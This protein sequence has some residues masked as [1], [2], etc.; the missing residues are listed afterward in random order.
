MER[1]SPQLTRQLASISGAGHPENYN[2]QWLVHKLRPISDYSDSW[3]WTIVER[4][5]GKSIRKIVE[6]LY[7][8]ELRKGAWLV[9]I[10]IWKTLFDQAVVATIHELTDKGY[11]CLLPGGQSWKDAVP[12]EPKNKSGISELRNAVRPRTIESAKHLTNVSA[13]P[14]GFSNELNRVPESVISVNGARMGPVKHRTVGT[15]TAPIDDKPGGSERPE[16]RKGNEDAAPMGQ[17][18]REPNPEDTR[19]EP[20]RG[21]ARN[22]AGAIFF[23]GRYGLPPS[24]VLEIPRLLRRLAHEGMRT[25]INFWRHTTESERR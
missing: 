15:R 9:D 2:L 8:D 14:A 16:E 12:A 20:E 23:G 13:S 19:R 17:R 6:T 22:G 10:G 1:N 18:T 4:C 21:A 24:F 3:E 25:A 7:L 11:I 5:N